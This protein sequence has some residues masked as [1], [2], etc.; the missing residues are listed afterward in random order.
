MKNIIISSRSS[1]KYCDPVG[2]NFFEAMVI[3]PGRF[4]AFIQEPVGSE[5]TKY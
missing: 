3:Y 5:S 2:L 1:K 4:F